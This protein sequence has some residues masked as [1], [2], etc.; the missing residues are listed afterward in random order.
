MRERIL[1]ADNLVLRLDRSK[2][3]VD[4][5]NK[6]FIVVIKPRRANPQS[7]DFI[8]RRACDECGSVETRY[9]RKERRHIFR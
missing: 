1:C 9:D 8:E 7:E 4:L 6:R 2:R 3:S 5:H